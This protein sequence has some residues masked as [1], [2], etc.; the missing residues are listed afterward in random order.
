M[1]S[2]DHGDGALT[3]DRHVRRCLLVVLAEGLAWQLH[4]GLIDHHPRSWRVQWMLGWSTV[5]AMLQISAF[6]YLLTYSSVDLALTPLFVQ[7]MQL[8]SL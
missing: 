2:V 1:C 8:L 3:F 7:H 6:A 5:S 4:A